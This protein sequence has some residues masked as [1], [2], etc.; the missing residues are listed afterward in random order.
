[1]INMLWASATWAIFHQA[2]QSLF[3]VAVLAGVGGYTS[4]LLGNAI[5]NTWFTMPIAFLV[6][7][8]TGMFF[9]ILAS[10]VL[11][12]IQFAVLNLAF[13][14]VFRYLLIAFT[15]ITNGIDGLK[16]KYFTPEDVFASIRNRYFVVITVSIIAL[17][18]IHKL[19][20]SRFGKILTLIGRN[21]ELSA[22]VG[23]NTDKYLRLAFLVFTPLIG[24][25]G[26][27][28]AHFIG[29]ISPE[30]WNADLSLT[31]VF[32]TLIGGSVNILGPMLGAIIA[33]GIPISFDVTAEFRFGI[34]GIVA[35]LIFIFKPEG[36][37][38]WIREL[39]IKKAEKKKNT[40]S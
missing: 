15:N 11:G 30:A 23:I 21:Q 18:A 2:G 38:G 16:V 28:Y 19:M 10:R 3:A 40:I 6:S 1:M 29:H 7:C 4:A 5:S 36:I 25:G 24:L 20:S 14:F 17:F 31:M 9:Y 27:L 33:T 22:S 13:I 35:I 32:S 37:V 8:V 34:A 26:I 39:L 12:H